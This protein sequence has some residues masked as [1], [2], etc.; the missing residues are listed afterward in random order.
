MVKTYRRPRRGKGWRDILNKGKKFLQDTKLISTVANQLANSGVAT[1][2]TAP[3]GSI[4]QK[5]GYGKRRK[6]GRG[7]KRMGRRGRGF[8]DWIKN[9]ALPF[10][11][12]TK[13]ISG[14]SGALST[15]PGPIGTVAKYVNTGA[16]AVGMGRRRKRGSGMRKKR[17]GRG[18]PYVGSLNNPQQGYGVGGTTTFSVARTSY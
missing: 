15:I 1:K 16:N 3:V 7:K 11:K 18:L 13:L 4:A 6:R 9:K 17:M 14:V 5:Y 10:L 8:V 2:Y 12:K